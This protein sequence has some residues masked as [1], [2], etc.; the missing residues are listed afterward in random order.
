MVETSIQEDTSD[1]KPWSILPQNLSIGVTRITCE[2]SY[3]F[4]GS[5]DSVEF[6]AKA[7]RFLLERSDAESSEVEKTLQEFV[8]LSRNDYL[9]TKG[10]KHPS[11]IAAWLALRLTHPTDAYTLTP[12]WHR[13][14]R[15]YEPDH[16][17]DINSKYAVTFL[18]NPTR[19]LAESELVTETMNKY[20][21]QENFESQIADALFS[22]PQLEIRRGQIARFSWGEED[23]PV[24]SEP[25]CLG[26]DRIFASILFGSAEELRR[27]CEY[28]CQ[29]Y[30]N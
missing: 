6:I 13:D 5:I 3:S 16:E 7:S 29:K 11:R 25:D 23:S 15:M 27:M 22:E 21:P 24:H 18:G 19:M 28:R 8:K 14:G 1:T 12:R 17:G 26:S 9:Q 20:T 10:P 2:E 30:E 4:Y